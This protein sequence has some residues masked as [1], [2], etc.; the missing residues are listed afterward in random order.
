M[1]NPNGI[2]M[3]LGFTNINRRQCDVSES[4]AH[5]STND[6]IGESSCFGPIDTE[7]FQSLSL[8][9]VVATDDGIHAIDCDHWDF[10]P[11][12][13]KL[14]DATV[15]VRVP[16]RH[17]DGQQGFVERIN[18]LTEV[19]ATRTREKSVNHHCP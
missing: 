2:V 17:D 7:G 18:A 16:M 11:P 1:E 19:A 4:Q 6:N 15:M 10:L 12:L 5:G 14:G 8:H 3:G 9:G 13:D